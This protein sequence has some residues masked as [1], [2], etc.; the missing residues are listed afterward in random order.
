MIQRE[1]YSKGNHETTALNAIVAQKQTKT[2]TTS[3]D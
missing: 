1:A 3:T 2:C